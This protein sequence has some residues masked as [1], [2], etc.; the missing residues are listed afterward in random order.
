[1]RRQQEASR[2]RYKLALLIKFSTTSTPVV[3]IHAL[4]RQ[5]KGNYDC[6][7]LE[8]APLLAGV[9]LSKVVVLLL[10]EG[11]N[12]SGSKLAGRNLPGEESVQFVKSSSLG[13]REAEVGPNKDDN[14]TSTPDKA[15]KEL[16]KNDP[17][18]F[19]ETY[20]V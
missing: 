13:L 15:A 20:P 19:R 17:P 16:A 3:L 6:L 9:L 1:M 18:R 14:S 5:D 12:V 2:V 8:M 11:V 7:S 4:P 10:I